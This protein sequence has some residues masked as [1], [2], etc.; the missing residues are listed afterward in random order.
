VAIYRVEVWTK[1]WLIM[2]INSLTK[3]DENEVCL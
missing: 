1:E 3:N 2:L